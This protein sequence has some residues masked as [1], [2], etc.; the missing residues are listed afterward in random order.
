MNGEYHPYVECVNQGP[1]FLQKHYSSSVK[2]HT[3]IDLEFL[4]QLFNDLIMPSQEDCGVIEPLTSRRKF[5]GKCFSNIFQLL[6]SYFIN[7]Y[8]LF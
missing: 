1:G 5:C 7:T 6:P 3:S 4:E 2:G 8:E